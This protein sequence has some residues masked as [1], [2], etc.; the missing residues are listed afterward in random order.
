MDFKSAD[1][2]AQNLEYN[3]NPDV[4]EQKEILYANNNNPSIFMEKNI[5]SA[6]D[7]RDDLKEVEEK[8]GF[9]GKLWN[10]FKNL[11]GLGTSSNDVEEKIEQYENG[12]ITYEEASSSINE[13]EQ[14]QNSAVDMA[15]SVASGLI[16]AGVT[17]ATGGVGLAASAA[18]GGGAKALIKTGDRATN[19]VEGDELDL[20]QIGKDTLTGAVDGVI[21]TATM[22]IGTSAKPVIGQTVKKAAAEGALKGAAQGAITGGVMGGTYYVADAVFE[23][24]VD[25][26]FEGL[27]KSTGQGAL[28]GG[29]MGGAIGGVTNGVKQAKVNKI[30]EKNKALGVTVPNK[31]AAEEGTSL[32]EKQAFELRESTEELSK[33]YKGNIEEVKKEYNRHFDDLESVETIT[34]RAKGEDS[35]SAKL[36][37]KFL[38]GELTSTDT[39]ACAEMI[40]D[41]YGTRIQLKNLSTDEARRIVENTGVKYDDFVRAV[42]SGENLSSEYIAALDSLKEAQT[43]EFADNFCKKIRSGE[44]RLTADDFNNYGTEIT[45]YFSDKQLRQIGEAYQE[46]TGRELTFVNKTKILKENARTYGSEAEAFFETKTGKAVKESGYASGQVNIESNITN[47]SMLSDTEVQIRGVEV[48][49]FADVEHIPYDIRTGKITSGTKKYAAVYDTIKGLSPESYSAYNQYLSDVYKHLR[50]KEMGIIT[51]M[52]TLSKSLTYASEKELIEA[53]IGSLLTRAGKTLKPAEIQR[54]TFNGLSKFHH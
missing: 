2:S 49:G 4:S 24:D 53:N 15:S 38:K 29:V 8:Q 26:S 20:K 6:E 27:L 5:K 47:G 45:S 30:V 25:F 12:E 51:Q 32:T 22:G 9:I 23:E 54:L 14:T 40:G 10:G 46:A 19:E 35:I 42:Q 44:I 17:A 11:T 48:N 1:I 3:Y 50:L 37:K 21:T 43:G 31:T 13:F 28:V 36:N 18:I 34:S 39:S 16:V 41:G 52:P 7:L 33:K